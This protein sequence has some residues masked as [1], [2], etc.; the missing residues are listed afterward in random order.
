MRRAKPRFVPRVPVQK[1]MI[2]SALMR[3]TIH[4]W[5]NLPLILV[6]NTVKETKYSIK[7]VPCI[8]PA[9][10]HRADFTLV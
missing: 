2:R 7:A 8:S 10:G 1:L 3:W 5:A 6:L 9:T 4:R